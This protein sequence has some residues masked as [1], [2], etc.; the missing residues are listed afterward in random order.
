MA[1]TADLDQAVAD[2]KGRCF[3]ALFSNLAT[4]KQTDEIAKDSQER[5]RRCIA[6]CERA[7]EL[8]EAVS[9]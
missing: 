2:C 3:A 7:R 1:M 4:G 8:A 6:T 9:E 5:Y